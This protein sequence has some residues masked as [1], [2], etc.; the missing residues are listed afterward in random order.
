[1]RD[2]ADRL[3]GGKRTLTPNNL[4]VFIEYPLKMFLEEH[5]L[6][7]WNI[8][9]IPMC[10]DFRSC[11]LYWMSSARSI[12]CQ[13]DA[14]GGPVLRARSV[15]QSLLTFSMGKQRMIPR[16]ETEPSFLL[17]VIGGPETSVP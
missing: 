5:M 17:E 8:G 13:R 2:A 15:P 4:I 6:I 9:A 7:Y 10:Y 16:S 11:G 1:M 12:L 3:T 14:R